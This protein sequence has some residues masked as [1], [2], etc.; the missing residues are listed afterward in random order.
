MDSHSPSPDQL[1]PVKRA[2]V[3]LRALRAKLKEAER[4]RDEPIAVIGMGC[5]FPGGANDPESLWRMLCA[6][7]DAV[8]EVPADRW[9][10]NEFFDSDPDAPGKMSTRWAGFLKD[11]DGF[12][13]DFFGVSPREAVTMDPQQRLLL[14]VGWE[15]LENAGQSPEKL[16]GSSTGV[17]VG[18]ASNDYA[19]LQMQ[20]GEL[21]EIG[22]YFATGTC[23]SVAPGRLSY[24]L[25]L[26]GPSIAVDTACSS[27]LV[28]VHLACQSLRLGESRMA[29]AGGVNVILAPELLINFSKSH[30]MAADGR[31][32]T[33]DASADGF[34]R[35]EGCGVV[36]LKRLTE[37]I[38]D[39]DNILAVIR[40][41]AINQDGRSSGLTVPNGSAQ[42]EVI[43]RALTNAG[44][45]P[46][47]VGYV[48]THGTGTSLGDPIEVHAL[49]AVYGADRSRQ[50]SLALGSIKSNIGHLETAAGV[51]GLIKAVLV[52]RH[53]ELPPQLH[54]K[55]PNP[56]IA[57][58]EMAVRVPVARTAWPSGSARRIAGLSS[59]GF[60]G[61]NVHMV[62]ESAATALELASAK[63]RDSIGDEMD[64]RPERQPGALV[65]RP[66]HLLTVSG[67]SAG[68]L[69][70]LVGR[71]AQYLADNPDV[72]LADVC[73]TANTGRS[74]FEHRVSAVAASMEQLRQ[75]LAA[76]AAGQ[77][78]VGVFRGHA[79][80]TRRPEV[81]FLFTGQGGQYVNMGRA[82][83]E[84]EPVF[85]EVVDR[86]DELLR[87]HLERPLREVLYPGE[88]RATPLDQ[89]QY[90][91]V[92]MFAVQYGLAQLW[93]SWGVEPGAVMGHSVGEIA[94]SAV[95]GMVGLEDGLMLMRER[96]RLMQSLPAS[97][98]MASL[99]AGEEQV[100]RALEGYRDRV[101]IAA[102]N[103]PASTVISGER[104][105][106]E[107]VLGKLEGEGVKT[108]VLKVSNS[109]HSPLVEP[110][111]E[112]FGEA[113][114]RARYRRPEVAQY[115]SM[116]LKWVEEGKLLDAA[117]WPYNLRHTV[118]FSEAIG[119]LWGQGYRVFVEIGPTPILASMGSQ[120]VPQGEGV[121]LPSLRQDR[122]D[123]E[124]MLE[125]VATLY[126]KGVKI[127]WQE[128]ERSHSH[129]KI[130]LPVYPWQRKPYRVEAAR[131]RQRGVTSP[132]SSRWQKAL[133]AAR[134]QSLH[135]PIDLN[136]A[137]Y[138]AKWQALDRV[139]TALM[140]R[141]LFELGAFHTPHV[142]H[143]V[144]S[145]L[146][147]LGI[148]ANYRMLMARW[149]EKLAAAGL[150][151][152][153][154]STYRL[155]QPL[156]GDAV[157]PFSGL[158]DESLSDI[159]FVLEYVS[160]CG[161]MA[162]AILTG[163]A[164][165]LDTLFPGGS[166]VLAEQIYGDWALS[167]YFNDIARSVV[168]SLVRNLPH[169]RQLRIAEIGAGTGGATSAL[170]PVLPA[171][172]THYCFTDAS[173][174]F[175]DR[176]REKYNQY[177]FLRFGLLDI[178]NKPAD[179]G[180]GEH[181]F[182]V[183]VACNVLHATRNLDETIENVLS[184]MGPGALLILCEVTRP[185]SWI[186]FTYGFMEDWHRFDDGL[187]QGSP[188]LSREDW[189][190]VLRSHG[191]EDV[192]A[193]PEYGSP[194]EILG[195]HCIVARAP[196]AARPE[197]SGQIDSWMED[198]GLASSTGA[199]ESRTAQAGTGRGE[200]FLN[201]LRQASPSEQRE[202]LVDL[203][204]GRTMKVLRRDASDLI[205]RRHRLMDL[206]IDS[207]MA[208]ELRNALSADLGLPRA[209]PATLI[210]DYPSVEAIAGYLAL[211]VLVP[212]P[213]PPEN[214]TGDGKSGVM[215]FP[216]GAVSIEDLSDEETEQL[217]L[218][219]LET[220]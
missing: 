208:V 50:N 105:A 13:A 173:R 135:V 82:L 134:A 138:P 196:S 214:Q 37:A 75:N 6:G 119:A 33:F 86:C 73:H 139:T 95:S 182:D 16:L 108:R 98:L 7:T 198:S 140:T 188:L 149:L 54:F 59:F 142:S 23:H 129:K 12:D 34:V 96:G 94:A 25:G 144:E 194:A 155:R 212:D 65:E 216:P 203:V 181:T 21:T 22:P 35:G 14:E 99:L 1:S 57:W 215:E 190:K 186:E 26:H 38:E 137:S 131:T 136:L 53:G 120:C 109:F 76:C 15:A 111:L 27:S 192:A 67:K 157:T 80:L 18:I 184:L 81:V 218:K 32:K 164:S 174:F 66:H 36:V 102:I 122:N 220:M 100:R 151:Q 147:D 49:H 69:E 162:A 125:D 55:E 206:G 70:E 28:A 88:G 87:G 165:A 158:A 189:E 58:K 29:L 180:F 116:R 211:R 19:Q 207:L 130:M 62:I 44:V 177:P 176:A 97:G 152:Q 92:A 183:I 3:E 91:H 161:Q 85:R 11:I 31:C 90:T 150:L 171:N 79:D 168:E 128:F 193:F 103:G 106:V 219:K 24:T 5:R 30:M 17:F 112:E 199:V 117:Y 107:E 115:S 172:R 83:Y 166:P 104:R 78:P 210:F 163:E 187:R 47:E 64:D 123:W 178:E 143:S 179:Q 113:A 217:L 121:W 132:V 197:R 4:V 127:D 213:A 48:E 159:P 124:Q 145:L 45:D 167:R 63:P 133:T 71:Y 191:F 175:F 146:Q 169:G 74:H 209:L 40:G 153:E 110:V 126:V 148:R 205:D 8:G 185:P 204:R 202:Q 51:A 118:R 93:R 52:L 141:T 114:G 200:S 9:D 170:L 101:A 56:H 160:R 77:E 2:I 43:R 42:Q 68:A 39:G 41:T 60:S 20:F 201:A 89:T 72:A 84:S 10:V 61:T 46:G 154:G 156:S 195:E